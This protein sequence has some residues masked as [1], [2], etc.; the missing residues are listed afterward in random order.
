MW[1]TLACWLLPRSAVARGASIAA[2][3]DDM[4]TPLHTA[5]ANGHIGAVE[6]L[7]AQQPCLESAHGPL[8]ESN[9]RM[10]DW[11]PFD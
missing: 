2:L 7:T 3:D 11:R 6:R 8:S 9:P 5:V 10:A 1:L 4:Q